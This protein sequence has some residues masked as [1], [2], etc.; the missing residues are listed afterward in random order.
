MGKG[1]MHYINN[2]KSFL[3]ILVII[4]HT[5]SAY[6]G[7][8]GW[9]YIESSN[10]FIS[11]SIL[12]L[13]NAIFQSFFMGLF[14][15]IAAYFSPRSYDNKGFYQFLKDR[16]PKLLIPAMFYFL[17]LNPLCINLVAKKNYFNSLGFYNMWF[18]IALLYFTLAYAIIRKVFTLKVRKYEFPSSKNTFIFIIFMGLLNFITRLFFPTNQLYIHDFSL[19]YFPQYI[20]LFLLGIIAYRN[21]WLN[22]IDNKMVTLYY[23]VSLISILTMPLVFF[24]VST[25]SSNLE[26]FYG[27]FTLESLYYSFWE[28]FTYVG[29]I[30][31][32]LYYFQHRLNYNN[33]F[34]QLTSRSSYSIYI[35]QAPII[36]SLQL[37]LKNLD[38]DI[39]LKVLLVVLI[40]FIVSLFFS[41]FLLKIPKLNKII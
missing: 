32:V 41:I 16:V 31:K 23:K 34:L 15:F 5:N 2:I 27:G 22:K 37:L 3:A 33:S 7:E 30:L 17:L 8:G 14:F 25:Y 12:T 9:Y 28:P 29:I 35:I 21:N 6:G 18:I 40:T 10:N 11:T 1:T 36:V 13:I 19:G 38:V 26:G 24:I 4:F 20:I 39:L